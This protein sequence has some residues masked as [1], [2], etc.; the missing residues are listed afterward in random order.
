MIKKILIFIFLNSI[1]LLADT[2]IVALSSVH[3]SFGNSGNNRVINDLIQFP[4]SNAEYSEITMSINLQCPNGGC[5]PWDRKA[6][7]SVEHLNNWFEIGRYVTPYGVECG[8]S[9]DVTDYRS[10]LEGT[11]NLRSYIDTWVEPGW[12]VTINFEFISGIPESPYIN[13]RKVWNYS[14]L[15]YG[16]DTNPINIPTFNGYIPSD[17]N[18][19]SLR[20]ITTGHGQGNTGNAAE[21]SYKLHDIHVNGDPVFVHD[22]WR[23]DCENNTCSPQNGSWVYDRAGFCPGDK[24]F[25]QDFNILDYSSTGQEVQ[26]DYVLQDYYNACSPN[27][28][29]CVDGATCPECNYN[30]NGH[31]E[32]FYFIE[33]QL[34]LHTNNHHSNADVTFRVI[35]QDTMNNTLGIYLEN[36]VPVYGFQ[37]NLVSDN[38]ET[39]YISGLTFNNGNGG[40]ADAEGWT[41]TT[42][43]SNLVIGLSQYTGSPIPPG[44][45]ILTYINYSD[46][47]FPQISGAVTISN[48]QVSGYFG[49]VLTHSVGLPF[50]F[51]FGLNIEDSNVIPTSHSLLPSYPNPFNPVLHIPFK[52]YKN[53]LTK[54]SI[55][56]VNGKE[57]FILID[58]ENKDK[59]SHLISWDAS[60]FASGLYF[61]RINAGSFMES[62]K[63]ILIK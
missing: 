27:N 9:F 60:L 20:M 33:S 47:N 43:D 52:L 2:T 3:H 40:R 8:W 51:E 41:V 24:V 38:Q 6:Q 63:I 48:L 46:E 28:P 58:N 25:P 12:L 61:V 13:I 22:F 5:D 36:Y 11:V 26:L 31:T 35:N 4:Q 56:D 30:Y 45:G 1:H 44:E 23:P 39:G 18:N 59:G 34:I 19:A 10:I 17:V 42:N 62:K 53:E 49:S 37:F 14:N 32:P 7:I 16:D 21:F 29:S 54:L 57:V 15:I 50:N 55:Y